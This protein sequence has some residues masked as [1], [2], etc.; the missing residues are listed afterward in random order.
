[1]RGPRPVSRRQVGLSG[2][3]FIGEGPKKSIL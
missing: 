3:A 2:Y 1:V